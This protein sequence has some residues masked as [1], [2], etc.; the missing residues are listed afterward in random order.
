MEICLW[1]C[2]NIWYLEDP[3]SLM[4][5]YL[6][7]ATAGTSSTYIYHP[8]LTRLWGLKS[9]GDIIS[10]SFMV[11]PWQSLSLSFFQAYH[12]IAVPDIFTTLCFEDIS[13]RF[14]KLDTPLQVLHSAT[15]PLSCWSSSV[16]SRTLLPF[17]RGLG[18]CQEASTFVARQSK[19]YGPVITHRRGADPVSPQKLKFCMSKS[20]EEIYTLIL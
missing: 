3:G 1:K 16:A 18:K 15:H 14:Q 6:V 7:S 20:E 2:Q 19:I 4:I 13:Q 17:L 11:L 12:A 10:G 8:Q 5:V 9:H